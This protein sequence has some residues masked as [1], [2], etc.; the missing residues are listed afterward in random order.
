MTATH[1]RSIR[2]ERAY[3]AHAEQNG[4]RVLVDRFWPRGKTKAD[5]HLD[6][7]AKELAPTSD[8]IKWFGHVPE[9]W[10]EF[11]RRYL[12]ELATT[13]AKD[14]MR[15]LLAGAGARDILLLYG[16]R[17]ERHNQAVV[18]REALLHME[19]HSRAR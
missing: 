14:A 13:D 12:H 1:Q 8:L 6:E 17:D 19:E 10:E 15:N 16:A 3:D 7:W 9:R 5:L 2:I 11:R 4:Y 18:L